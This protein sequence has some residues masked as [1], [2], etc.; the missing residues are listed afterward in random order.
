MNF[1]FAAATLQTVLI[2]STV[3]A[4]KS[5]SISIVSVKYIGIICPLDNGHSIFNIATTSFVLLSS[6][7]LLLALD[8]LAFLSSPQRVYITHTWFQKLAPKDCSKTFKSNLVPLSNLGSWP[9][10]V[11]QN[12]LTSLTSLYKNLIIS[13]IC[14]ASADS[15]SWSP[16]VSTTASLPSHPNNFPCYRDVIYVHEFIPAD[17]LN[18]SSLSEVSPYKNALQRVLF[19]VPVFPM[20]QRVTLDS[21][22][23]VYLLPILDPSSTTISRP[24][25][26][27]PISF[28]SGRTVIIGV[29]GYI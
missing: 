4:N 5:S 19:P 29:G 17:V 28:K 18:N 1:S 24:I 12:N 7:R 3:G 6:V 13:T 14:Y 22:T 11:K 25:S 15:L 10:T 23:M 21:P 16:G 27:S 2:Y 20:T 9:L 8:N 26:H